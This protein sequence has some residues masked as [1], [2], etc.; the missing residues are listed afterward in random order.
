MTP[1]EAIKFLQE[2][3]AND[4]VDGRFKV[5]MTYVS[6]LRTLNAAVVELAAIKQVEIDK[7]KAEIFKDDGG[8]EEQ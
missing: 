4:Q 3:Q 6:A 1:E 7:G 2:L 5:Q 8:G